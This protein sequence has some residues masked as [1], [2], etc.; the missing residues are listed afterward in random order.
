MNEVVLRGRDPELLLSDANCYGE[1]NLKSVPEWGNELFEQMKQVAEL[2][3][4][5]YK[6]SKYSEAI[7]REQ[8]KI[9]D[10]SLTP[11]A[12]LLSIIQEQ[13]LSQFALDKASEYQQEAKKRGYQSY[14]QAFFD[15]SV[16]A[17]HKTQADI[18]AGDK[19]NFDDF[20]SDY[21]A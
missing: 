2:L 17:S 4:K 6:T 8:A 18:E 1:V 14:D 7:V 20:L 5:S 19:L 9:N 3:D 16:P 11:S 12:Q 15:Q 21:F 10:S 13:S